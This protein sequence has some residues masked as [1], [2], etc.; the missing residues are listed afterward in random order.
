MLLNQAISGRSFFRAAAFVPVTLSFVAVG[1]LW[2]WIYN[3]V[4]GLLNA[5]LDLVGLEA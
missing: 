4:F 2:A 3:P 1:L 5:A